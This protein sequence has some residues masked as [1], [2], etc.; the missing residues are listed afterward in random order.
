MLK[1]HTPRNIG[2][3]S[4]ADGMAWSTACWD[5]F[6]Y[7]MWGFL[8]TW[9]CCERTY[10]I[11]DSPILA[12]LREYQLNHLTFVF[13]TTCSNTARWCIHSWIWHWL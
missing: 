2:D 3:C 9:N 8:T 4:V 10:V 1:L 13:K 7:A 6:S 11:T 5:L 12:Q